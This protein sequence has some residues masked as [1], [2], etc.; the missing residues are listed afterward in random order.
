MASTRTSSAPMPIRIMMQDPG[1]RQSRREKHQQIAAARSH[2]AKHIAREARWQRQVN[3][4]Q[5]KNSHSSG[6]ATSSDKASDDD[7]DRRGSQSVIQ[8]ALSQNRRDP[9]S[10]YDASQHPTIFQELIE[11]AYDTLWPNLIEV[12][13]NP[14]IHPGR[15]EW[16]LAAQENPAVY[17]VHLASVADFGKAIYHAHGLSGQFDR[18][19]LFHH[20]QALGL[21][22]QMIQSM[23]TNGIPTDA[24]VMAVYNLSYQGTGWDYRIIPESHPPSPVFKSRFLGGYGRK[25]PHDDHIRAMNTL[26]RAKGGLEEVRLVGIAEMIWLWSLDN[27]SAHI[28]TPDFPLLKQYEAALVDYKRKLAT[29]LRDGTPEGQGSAFLVLSGRGDICRL[30]DCLL[31]TATIT[32]ELGVLA[33]GD[34]GACS[35]RGLLKIARANHHQ[36]LSIPAD[37]K[38]HDTGED[39]EDRI[40]FS[41]TRL[42]A[43]LYHDIV[44][45]PQVDTSGIKPRLADQLRHNLSR[46]S[47]S[48]APRAG[49]I[50]YRGLV[51]WA[52][53][54][55]SIGSTWTK[56]RNWFVEQLHRRSKLL[57]IETFAELKTYMS[58]YIWFENMDGPALRAWSEGEAAVLSSDEDG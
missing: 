28:R 9:F 50:E 23:G 55:G 29:S 57:G 21:V 38:D 14:V 5:E 41:V 4:R 54:L 27:C 46:R 51:L 45:F 3:W 8:T 58:R 56:N 25:V 26:I 13:G 18:L 2:A 44:I 47:P 53:L 42:A 49:R 35:F 15:R 52:L 31:C 1:S 34:E 20:T 32:A 36:L 7:E 39:E 48:L 6:R 19:R 11:Y 43:L 33:Q 30:R 22:R 10:P 40:I 24:L 16:R 12:S 37:S 17:H